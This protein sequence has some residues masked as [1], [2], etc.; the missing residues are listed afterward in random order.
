MFLL[1][2]CLGENSFTAGSSV[3]VE[4]WM[5]VYELKAHFRSK[6]KVDFLITLCEREA[7]STGLWNSPFVG[8]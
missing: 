8:L 2:L 7:L 4:T 3:R 6:S 1:V 5:Q